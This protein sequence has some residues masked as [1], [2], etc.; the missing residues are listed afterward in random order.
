MRWFIRTNQRPEQRAE[1]RLAVDVGSILE[2][3]DQL[4]MA[5]F[6]EHMAFNGTENF[7]KQELVD[8]LQSIGMRFGADINAYTAF[9]ETVYRLTVPTDDP[10]LLDT[11]MLVFGDWAGRVAFEGEEIDAERGVVLEEWRRG[12]GAARRVLDR[13]L[14]VIFAD[15]RYAERLPIGTAERIENA[16]HDA[17]RRYYRDWYRPELM[18]VIAVGDFD[19][20]RME[21]LIREHLGGLENPAQPRERATVELP[22]SP[23]PRVS[24]ETDPELTRTQVTVMFRHEPETTG[25]LA[26]YRRGLVEGSTTRCS[27]PAWARSRNPSR[28]LSCSR[29]PAAASWCA[30][31]ASTNSTPWPARERSS[32]PGSRAHRGRAGRPPRL[33]RRRARTRPRP[34]CCAASSKRTANETNNPR[35]GSPTSS[36]VTRSKARSSRASR[37]SARSPAASFPEITLDEVNSLGQS[38]ITDEN[39]VVLVSG[40]ER[41]GTELPAEA[42][43]LARFEAVDALTIEPW[44]DRT[45]DEPLLAE[46]PTPSPV[47]STRAFEEIGVTE[48]TLGNGVTVILKPT[49]FQNDQV[50]LAGWSPGGTSLVSAEDHVSSTLATF[51]LSQG[52][53]GEFDLIELQKQ[54]AGKVANAFTML[55]EL[56]EGVNASASPEDLETMFQLVYLNMTAPRLDDRAYNNVVQRLTAMLENRSKSPETAFRDEFTRRQSQDHPRRRPLD[57]EVLGELDPEKALAIYRERFADASD[58]HFVMV[59]NFDLDA[60]QPLVETYLGGLPTTDREESWRDVGVRP[61]TG[62]ERFTVERGVEPKSLV[63]MSFQGPA[64]GVARIVS[65]C[66]AWSDRS[67]SGSPSWCARS[68]ARPT[69]SASTARSNAPRGRITKSASV[70]PAIHSK[71]IRP[72]TRSSQ[73]SS[74]CAPRAHRP[75][76]SPR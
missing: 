37:S 33:H 20:D 43:L 44:V 46:T 22:D 11:A 52:G 42:T 8:Y 67:R 16:P 73:S 26:D 4:G 10:E 59:G 68:S 24:I 21:A 30:R 6:V 58:F 23:E 31:R 18:S 2:D 64:R 61:P 76:W 3:P 49:D 40:P 48:W 66:S 15:S 34:R 36:C 63:Q 56:Q 74:A 51:V 72:S 54:L 32:G 13:Q 45:R 17:L 70:S 35:R 50:L 39:R 14:P 71:S 57:V 75:R 19:A 25:T 41:E 65:C 28:H 60:V 38:F 62:V 1:L 53:V 7:E 69:P 5:H 47:E 29:P 12:R 55:G 27:T 9:D